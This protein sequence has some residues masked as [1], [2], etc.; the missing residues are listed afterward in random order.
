VD[1]NGAIYTQAGPNPDP[2]NGSVPSMQVLYSNGAP[3]VPVGSRLFNGSTNTAM[4]FD[5]SGRANQDFYVFVAGTRSGASYPGAPA[6]LLLVTRANGIHAF[7]KPKSA[8][9]TTPWQRL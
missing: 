7:Y 4:F 5:S 9:G 8:S 2:L 3:S 6:G 1:I